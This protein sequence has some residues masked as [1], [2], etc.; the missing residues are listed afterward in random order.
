MQIQK[1]RNNL[2]IIYGLPGSGKST[3][4]ST[5]SNKMRIKNPESRIE[6]IDPDNIEQELKVKEKG[7]DFHPADSNP[8]EFNSQIWN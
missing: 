2:I 8:N 5:I 4:A 1:S 6:I 3:L 7:A